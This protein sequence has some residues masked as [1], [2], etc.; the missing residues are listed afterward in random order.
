MSKKQIIVAYFAM[1]LIT[2][3]YAQTAERKLY[4]G[5]NSTEATLEFN[6]AIQYNFTS[7]HPKDK[8]IR[9][10][11]ENQLEHIVG[12]MS[13]A[14]ITAVPKGDHI[15]S[16]IKVL[17]QKGKTLN[18]SYHYKGTAIVANGAKNSYD[19]VMPINPGTIYKTSMV[20]K[21]N[22]C[23]DDHYQSEGDFWYF[24]NPHNPGCN[25]VL[26]KDYFIIKASVVRF[27]NTKLSYPEYQNLPD[28]NGNITIH[29]LFGMDEVEHDRNPLKSEDVNAT[30]FQELHS[31][32]LKKGYSLTVWSDDQIRAI[33]KTQND[34]VLPYVETLQ[35]GKLIYRLF[36][37]PTGIDENS[38]AFHWFFKDAVE[39][40]SVMIYG[41][42]SGLGGH[43]DLDSIEEDLGVKINF[44]TNQ[45]QIFFFDSCTSYRY[46]N[47]MY[48]DR[49]KTASDP[50]GTKKLD[51]FTNGLSTTFTSMQNANAALAIAFE[52]SLQ[53]AVTG[54]GYVS[55]QT[56]AKQIDSEN[57]FG[58]NGDEDNVVP[59]KIK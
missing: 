53:Y 30:N 11:I 51:I 39:N 22:P 9:N 34:A 29:A 48:F 38:Q 7:L 18:I 54:T 46:Y 33:A 26:G 2:N 59:S 21:V 52:T 31:N 36:F 10:A 41:G 23:T 6:G 28:K 40:A 16:D 49:K 58:I 43:L 42:H 57:L 15:V 5:S 4:V 50:N 3:I 55:Y 17:A 47:S 13:A 35:K 45:Y 37:G 19:V 1:G 12:P 14:A 56:L 24:W 25:L 20:G 32:L 8:T 44:N 27:T